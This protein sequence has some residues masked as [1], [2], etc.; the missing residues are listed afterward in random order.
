M[1]N[2]SSAVAGDAAPLTASTVCFQSTDYAF[3]V[4]QI[5]RGAARVT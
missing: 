3:F 5:L 4:H 2:D 1:H